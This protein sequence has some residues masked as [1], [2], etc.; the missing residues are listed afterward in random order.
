MNTRGGRIK[1]GWQM[2]AKS[3]N[4]VQGDWALLALPLLSMATTLVAAAIIFAP[5]SYY[6]VHDHSRAP[7]I[8][9]VV[10]GAYPLTFISTFFNVAFV[11]V[12]RRK[13]N[14]EQTELRDGLA[15]A[16]SRLGAIAAWAL[17]STLVGL[18][19]RALERVRGGVI[20]E[21]I[22]A[23][24]LGAVWSLAT[25]FVVPILAAEGV[26]PIKT[27]KRSA[28]LIHARWGEGITGSFVI[29]AAFS[30]L[31]IPVVI[32]GVIGW[33]S[34]AASHAF[35]VI[36]IAI[37]AGLFLLV[38]AAQNAVTQVF[39][40]ALYDYAAG[41]PTATAVFSEDDLQSAMR[42]KKRR[43]GR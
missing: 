20:A 4:V 19:L 34:F 37:A 16:R 14:G 10:I 23:V 21:R 6:A 32:V 35:G 41:T 5:A 12:V 18:A 13:L 39:H 9:A 30:L 33:E 8:L 38:S 17:L 27:L 42:P 29:G 22:A 2:S 43:F 24:L 28:K 15:C 1:R 7:F 36:A 26:G 11:A 3:W 25:L 31:T 40:L